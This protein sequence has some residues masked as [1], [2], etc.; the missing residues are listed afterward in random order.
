MSYD[1]RR[2]TSRDLPLMA[3]LNRLFGEVFG[4][5]ESYTGR[6]PGPEYLRRLLDD[7]SFVALVALSAGEVAGGLA[8]YELRKFERERCEIYIYD[9]AVQEAQRRRGIATALIEELR[10]LAAERGAHVIY[11]QADTGEEDEAAIALYSRLG[12][13]E[14]VLHF[15][16][17]VQAS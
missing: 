8:A 12:T 7:P 15:D 17:P 13:R 2:L 9:L 1:I 11:V 5:A 10:R 6:P 4:D 16:I 14:E 3:A